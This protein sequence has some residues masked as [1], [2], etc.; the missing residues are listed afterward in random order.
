MRKSLETHWRLK[1]SLVS[2]GGNTQKQRITISCVPCQIR[3]KP[4]ESSQHNRGVPNPALDL[5]GG[6]STKEYSLW[7]VIDSET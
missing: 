1:L 7:M 3:N 2:K 5:Q 4:R 6:E